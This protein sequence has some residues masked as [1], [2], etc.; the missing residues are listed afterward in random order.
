MISSAATT[1]PQREDGQAGAKRASGEPVIALPTARLVMVTLGACAMAGAAS[2]LLARIAWPGQGLA[3]VGPASAAVAAVAM[4]GGLL[5][6]APW[7]ARP[8]GLWPTFWLASTV[9]RMLLTPILAYLLYSATPFGAAAVAIN[10]VAA[11]LLALAGEVV[12][13]AGFLKRALPA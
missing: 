4:V 8:I 5:A 1:T 10:V 9:L 11:Y 6:V 7:K 2:S 13:L 3:V 12:V